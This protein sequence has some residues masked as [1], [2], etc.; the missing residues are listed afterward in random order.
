MLTG[1]RASTPLYAVFHPL[2]HVC[3]KRTTPTGPRAVGFLS[4][5]FARPSV[6]PLSGGSC[7]PRLSA[8]SLSSPR[9]LTWEE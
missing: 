1:C 3:P 6:A 8:S 9:H 7:S 4:R 2:N 5:S